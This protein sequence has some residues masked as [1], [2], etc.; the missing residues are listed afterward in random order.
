MKTDSV[1][2]WKDKKGKL[3]KRYKTLTDKDLRF[4]EGKEEEMIKVLAFKLGK[5]K[6]ELLN[7][8]ITL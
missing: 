4:D 5:T 6:Q 2:Y 3:L 1:G 7:I 8:I